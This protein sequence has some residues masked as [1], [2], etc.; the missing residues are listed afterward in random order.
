MFG[1]VVLGIEHE[2]FETR[3]EAI[4]EEEGVF[5]DVDLSADALKRLTEEYKQVY[6]EHNVVFPE[7]PMDQLKACV[8]AVFGS[9]MADRAVRYREINGIENLLGTACNIQTMVSAPACCLKLG[10]VA[11]YMLLNLLNGFDFR[12][13][14]T[15][16]KTRERVLPFLATQE[17]AKTSCTESI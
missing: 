3:L 8:S 13:L 5:D 1:D 12:S 7:D 15:W 16:V 11:Q 6:V 14:E 10:L 9:W 17:P 2:A 4:K